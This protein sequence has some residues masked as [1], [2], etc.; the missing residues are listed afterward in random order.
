MV[1]LKC[2]TYNCRG[3]NSGKIVLQDFIDS[4]DLCFIQEHWLITEQLHQINNINHDFLSVSVSG[5]DSSLLHVGRPFGSC[6]ILYRKSLSSCITP[7]S[8]SSNRFCAIKFQDSTGLSFLL[9]AW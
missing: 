1:P 8:V 4:V 3:W 2:C 6:S 5:M 9:N 7:V